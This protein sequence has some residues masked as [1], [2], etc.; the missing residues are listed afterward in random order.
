RWLPFGPARPRTAFPTGRPCGRGRPTAWPGLPV[1]SVGPSTA[2]LALRP[3]TVSPRARPSLGSRCLRHRQ[4]PP[5][6]PS[7]GLPAQVE[8]DVLHLAV[9]VEAQLAML[10]PQPTLL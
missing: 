7:A 8:M 10:A 9:L 3:R 4:V 5:G 6:M 2:N 1:G